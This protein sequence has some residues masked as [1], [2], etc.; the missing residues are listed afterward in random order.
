LRRGIALKT[1]GN[2]R[3]TAAFTDGCTCY[4]PRPETSYIPNNRI[5]LRSKPMRDIGV[6]NLVGRHIP[7][8]LKDEIAGLLS[9]KPPSV[10]T[11]PPYGTMVLE[12]SGISEPASLSTRKSSWRGSGS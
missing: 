10:A 6:K 8:M 5:S 3:K 7:A 1:C 12:I 4:D 11:I 9:A 2:L